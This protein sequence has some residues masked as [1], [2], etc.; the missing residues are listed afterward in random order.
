MAA[1][2]ERDAASSLPTRSR[3][4][5][6][7]AAAG[8]AAMLAFIAATNRWLGWAASLR[9]VQA[10]DEH[11][12]RRIAA[13][14]PSLPHG[15]IQNQHGQR[16]VFHYLIGLIARGL[17]TGL[18]GTYTVITVLVVVAL[19]GVLGL[20]LTQV[21]LSGPQWALCL[22]VFVLNTYS[23]RYYLIARGEVTDLIFDLG[24]ALSLLG[25]FRR[26]WWVIL[27]GTAV[28]ALARQTEL[29][30]AVMVGVALLVWPGSGE[31]TATLRWGR[32]LAPG[33]LALI[34]YVLEV[35]VA[36]G[37]SY[38]TTP[39]LLH[40][41]VLAEL[42]ALPHSAGL[43]AQHL[44][45]SVNGLAAVG[46]V[47]LAGLI[48]ARAEIGLARLGAVFWATLGVALAVAAQPLALSARYAEHNETRL[49]VLGLGALVCAAAV[50]WH[51]LD[52]GGRRLRPG[53]AAVVVGVLG[54]G[55]LHHLYT[56]IGTA[57]AVQ[58]VVLQ[59][60][61]ALI[62]FGIVLRALHRTGPAANQ[63]GPDR[64]GDR[65]AVVAPRGAGRATEL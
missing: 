36:R 60:V 31:L 33:L 48:V 23:L 42:G 37:F 62:V 54:V 38:N 28:G 59:A 50:L 45:R 18:P 22:A 6:W 63:P 43:L 3:A 41:T 47:L 61:A 32:A 65:R 30:A 35:R 51:R 40:F 7:S 12:Y 4:W 19:V 52:P 44:L 8:A 5:K 17:G 53:E 20:L 24:L 58:T 26:R 27:A 11:D 1:A 29:P 14:A 64:G 15:G 56:V 2:A 55:S 46:A 34:I 25:L 10:N 49:S 16:F 21:G 39:S 57:D 9:L 13:A